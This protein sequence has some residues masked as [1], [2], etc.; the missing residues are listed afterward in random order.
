MTIDLSN[1]M[2]RQFLCEG[3]SKIAPADPNAFANVQALLADMIGQLVGDLGAGYAIHAAK[4]A[5]RSRASVWRC[6]GGMTRRSDCTRPSIP[7]DLA[8]APFLDHVGKVVAEQFA[9]PRR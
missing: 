8:A 6:T 9:R 3:S 1:I 7:R 5:L 4:S 2:L